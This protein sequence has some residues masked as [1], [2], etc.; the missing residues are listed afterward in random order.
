M[1]E[2]RFGVIT[3]LTGHH[4]TVQFDDFDDVRIFRRAPQ[5]V[6]RVE[7]SGSVRRVTTG[8]I[9]V[10]QGL[11]NAEPPRWNVAVG[12]HVTVVQEKDLR[13]HILMDPAN[14][15]RNGM[16]GTPRQFWLALTAHAHHLEALNRDLI[17]LG[18]SRIDLKPHQVSVVHRVISAYPHRFLLC[19][20]V[21]LGKTIEAG[22]ILK[23]LRARK[24]ADRVLIVVPPNL[25]RQWQY[26]LKTKF[27]ETFSIINS[28]TARYLRNQHGADT[29]P[30]EHIKSSIVSSSWITTREWNRLATAVDWDLVIVD[31]AHHARVRYIGNKV[32]RTKLYRVV[33]QLV[34]PQTFSKRS[35]LFLTATPMQLD[36]GEIY[37]LIE[38]LDPALF[39]TLGHF[40]NHRDRV[41][42]L[43][44]LVQDL[45][46]NGYADRD[47]QEEILAKVSGWLG[48]EATRVEAE[49]CAGPEG[50]AAVCDELADE[51]LLS[52]ILIR[53]R[54]KVVGGFMPRQAHRWEVA[55]TEAERT[56]LNAVEDY[57]RNGYQLAATQ[58]NT[59]IG[60][61]MVIFQKLMASSTRAL[62]MS[63]D[64]RRSKL[65]QDSTTAAAATALAKPLLDLAERLDEE[66][67]D[68]AVLSQLLTA[69]GDLSQKEAAELRHLVRLLDELP[70]DSKADALIAGLKD[71]ER[72]EEN[73]KVLLFTEF[74]QTQ[75]YLKARLE[76]ELGWKVHLFHGQ[77]KPAAKDEEVE[78]FR[79]SDKP[80]ILLSTEAGGEGRNFQ[81]CHLLVN[82][83]LPW[84][85]MRVEQRIG[86]VDR[87]GQTNVVQVFNFWIRGT[88]EERVLDVLENRIGI[89]EQTVGG[90]DPIL[91]DTETDLKRIFQLGDAERDAELAKYEADVGKRIAEAREAEE[92]LRDFIMETKSFSKEVVQELEEGSQ[93]IP[94]GD[95]ERFGL[96]LL[97]DVNTWLREEPDGTYKIAFHE[98]FISDYPRHTKDVGTKRTVT[99]RPDVAPD[100]E[101]VEY[102]ALGHPVI[103]DLVERVTQQKY[104]G[105]AT[106]V[107]VPADASL[108][109]ASGWLVIHQ[110]T[111]PGL[112]TI[113][114]LHTSFVD[115]QTG[116]D[117]DRAKL[118]VERATHLENDAAIVPEE[119]EA[120][121]FDSLDAAI[122]EAGEHAWTVSAALE[123]DAAKDAQSRLM[124]E[125]DKINAFFDYRDKAAADKLDQ[126]RKTLDRLTASKD[127]GDRQILPV[128]QSTVQGNEGLVERLGRERMERLAELHRQ[129]QGVGDVTLLGVARVEIRAAPDAQ[130]ET[131]AD[132]LVGSDTE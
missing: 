96:A 30:F 83:D 103:D 65:E 131:V 10:V 88:I 89:F 24:G 17:A 74:R 109:P 110:I 92:K 122:T 56:A 9:G 23:E 90:L 50:I 126:S 57:V 63:L 115:D 113:R 97:A 12:S 91:G 86:R 104:D 41:P 55:L 47:N 119:I 99:F 77:L 106:G 28:E 128:W 4:V 34:S 16:V 1:G 85:P 71:L 78:A 73:P 45:K 114:E 11:S 43:N 117:E 19:D 118:L 67:D 29:N 14:R 76:E 58:N 26:E 53:N 3:E 69:I 64:K 35:A 107:V 93:R 5:I 15:L 37:G 39:P 32:E 27:N 60:F 72:Q 123:A 13:P 7:L 21:G 98:P 2:E 124:R 70:T 61:V 66:V 82:Y 95:M 8:E 49:L 111:V 105:S 51:H 48:K 20:E 129:S 100:S 22:V 132:N 44:A 87:L 79:T 18:E 54:K 36:P 33:E 40:T 46:I 81:F 68:E 42:G 75:E 52:Q 62:R 127:P 130:S 101:H 94:A 38:L 112:K 59:A 84:N 6:R 102:M 80:T 125:V 25:M 120:A 116:P 31:E 108:E 121:V